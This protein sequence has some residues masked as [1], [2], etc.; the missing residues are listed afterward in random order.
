MIYWY[1]R[2][3]IGVGDINYALGTYHDLENPS[4]ANVSYDLNIYLLKDF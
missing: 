1:K 3:F 4:D 2:A